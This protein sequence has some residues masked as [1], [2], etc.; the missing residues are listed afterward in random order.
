MSK[1]RIRKPDNRPKPSTSADPYE[2][3]RARLVAA[4]QNPENLN[5][6][7]AAIARQ[8]LVSE[9]FVRY[10]RAEMT[11]GIEAARKVAARKTAKP[12]LPPSMQKKKPRK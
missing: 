12:I 1:K 4:L 2:A 6:S 5:K 10:V 9:K 11:G 7:S 8:C 3:K